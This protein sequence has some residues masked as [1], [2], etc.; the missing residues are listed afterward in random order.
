VVGAKKSSIIMAD[1]S[2]AD[3]VRVNRGEVNIKTHE[4]MVRNWSFKIQ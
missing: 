3:I 2:H 4:S 1:I